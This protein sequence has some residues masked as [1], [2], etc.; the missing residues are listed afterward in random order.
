MNRFERNS[1]KRQTI[2]E[3]RYKNWRL[4]GLAVAL[5]VLTG[6][7]A[8]SQAIQT[9]TSPATPVPTLILNTIVPSVMDTPSDPSVCAYVLVS[10]D[11]PDA[12]AMIN[13]AYRSANFTN[14]DVRAAAYGENCIDTNTNRVVSFSA[15]QTDIYLTVPVQDIHDEQALGNWVARLTPVID[16]VPAG[17]LPGPN[18]GNISVQFIDSSGTVTLWFPR[19][20]AQELIQKGI[21]GSALYEALLAANTP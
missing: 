14:I 11:A 4:A 3:R 6:C 10:K 13:Q 5:L 17:Q 12:A 1:N 2:K 15:M 20:S 8:V 21:D 19:K 7:A 9:P 16:L 18:P